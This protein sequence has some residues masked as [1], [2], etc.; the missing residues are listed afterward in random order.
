[1]Y[2]EAQVEHSQGRGERVMRWLRLVY[3]PSATRKRRRPFEPWI[4]FQSQHK[5]WHVL[6]ARVIG[7][8]ERVA[9]GRL[10]FL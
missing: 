4:V 9:N 5:A 1:M 3:A 7:R 8:L 10:G 2:V 6:F